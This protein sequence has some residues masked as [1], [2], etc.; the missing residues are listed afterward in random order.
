[1]RITATA[2]DSA[3]VKKG[4]KIATDRETGPSP[5]SMGGSLLAIKA[6]YQERQKMFHR[7]RDIGKA[8]PN[9]R[10]LPFGQHSVFSKS[11]DNLV[12]KHL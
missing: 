8:S 10:L 9:T 1:M 5:D 4:I 3:A 2:A 11:S 7:N 6:R 12:V